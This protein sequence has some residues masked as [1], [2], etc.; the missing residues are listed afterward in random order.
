MTI[1]IVNQR[2]RKGSNGRHSRRLSWPL[3]RLSEFWQASQRRLQTSS[4]QIVQI[5][6]ACSIGWSETQVQ[7]VGNAGLAMVQL[8]AASGKGLIQADDHFTLGFRSK[9]L[10]GALS[11]TT[12]LQ[13]TAN[14]I[15][16]RVLFELHINQSSTAEVDAVP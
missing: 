7:R 6:L 2:F 16:R 4:T 11:H 13:G 9:A 1:S 15:E 8:S 12:L 3:H 5:R 14:R 10:D